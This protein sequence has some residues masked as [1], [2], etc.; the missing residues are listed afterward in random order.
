METLLNVAARACDSA[1]GLARA[2]KIENTL[3]WRIWRLVQAR[4]GEEAAGFVVGPAALEKL[5]TA[6]ARRSV[7]Q[8]L[9]D[10]V[11]DTHCAYRLFVERRAGDEPTL[12]TML[13]ATSADPAAIENAN[14][15]MFNANCLRVGVQAASQLR[16]CV[17]YP[18]SLEGIS[19]AAV[20]DM[21][22]NLWWLRGEGQAVFRVVRLFHTSPADDDPGSPVLHLSTPLDPAETSVA[23]NGAT[24]TVPFMPR[25]CA[26]GATTVDCQQIGGSMVY[27]IKPVA[28]GLDQTATMC[29][30]E[31]Q[32]DCILPLTEDPQMIFSTACLIPSESLVLEVYVYEDLVKEGFA[33]RPMI[34]DMLFRPPEASLWSPRV[35][36]AAIGGSF[37]AIPPTAMID[38]PLKSTVY[39][40]LVSHVFERIG[41][42]REQF[43][44]YRLRLPTPRLGL[45]VSLIAGEDVDQ[46][47][48]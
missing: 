17:M 29:F 37:A 33:Y 36:P 15:L 44:C 46:P 5:L 10:A 8:T 20:V 41:M 18:G 27:F 9:I 39:R 28:I 32:H 38:S 30:G 14:R 19:S 43:H 1:T 4:T 47:E 40:D 23:E 48:S 22:S 16:C 45:M 26:G 21:F 6:C 13:T 2:L 31:I 12:R 42:K 7:D 3:A 11:R 34:T 25:F 35:E 24:P